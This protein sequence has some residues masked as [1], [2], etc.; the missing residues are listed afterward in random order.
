M[1]E[2]VLKNLKEQAKVKEVLLS[3]H[4]FWLRLG[5]EVVANRVAASEW[6]QLPS[7]THGAVQGRKR[8]RAGA[9]CAWRS[10]MCPAH[11]RPA[12]TPSLLPPCCTGGDAVVSAS[13]LEAFMRDWFL[14]DPDLAR[15][16]APNK[17]VN[18]L[19]PKAYWVSLL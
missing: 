19:Q 6:S 4:P 8:W 14:R 18:G 13:D 9:N 7:P 16:H 3:Y 11:G 1:Q 5:M 12:Q 15:R 2:A 10:G 17:A